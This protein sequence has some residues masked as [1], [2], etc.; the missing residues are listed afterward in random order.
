M[1]RQPFQLRIS[2][3]A[4]C[5]MLLTL[6]LPV[7]AFAYGESISL[8]PT[9]GPPGTNVRVT[10]SGFG[11]NYDVPIELGGSP[12]SVV[13]AH[14]NNN[15]D[16]TTRFT[17]PASTP[18]GNLRVSAIIGNGG[19]ADADFTVTA[20][21]QPTNASV[22]LSPPEGPPTTVV[23]AAGRGFTPSQPVQVTQ[24]GG[25][26]ITGGGGTVRADQSGAISMSFRIADQTPPGVITVTFRQSATIATAQFRV[27]PSLSNQPSGGQLGQVA[28]ATGLAWQ[29][30]DTL[31]NV[32]GIDHCQYVPP[33]ISQVISQ[34]GKALNIGNLA[35]A[36]GMGV[37]VGNDLAALNNAI[38]GHVKG[39]PYSAGA[40]A[41]RKKAGNDTRALH[42]ALT[43]AVPGLSLVFPV[44]PPF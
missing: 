20:A 4:I 29:I 28:Q 36:A 31:N 22:T 6:L 42:E 5:A 18:P 3:A 37:V 43:S 16:F 21:S 23:T 7:T 35:Y 40:L 8:N 27:T 11:P 25:P 34:I 12:G 14:A 19:S 24:A 26:G 44:P 17:I 10:G 15:G 32:C 13:T 2:L 38:K 1:N 39:T 30:I 33:D 41:L 9:Q